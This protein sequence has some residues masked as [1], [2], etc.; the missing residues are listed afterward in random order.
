MNEKKYLPLACNTPGS[1]RT[2][3]FVT[4]FS[5]AESVRMSADTF[6]SGRTCLVMFLLVKSSR[7]LNLSGSGLKKKSESDRYSHTSRRALSMWARSIGL[8]SLIFPFNPW[9]SMS[10]V[11]TGKGSPYLSSE[12]SLSTRRHQTL[13]FVLRKLGRDLN[14][15]GSRRRRWLVDVSSA[16]G[17]PCGVTGN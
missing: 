16:C 14:D 6:W 5:M 12:E 7:G 10:E 13:Y 3:S 17:V 15:M 4:S 1:T 11:T 9:M 8:S 2:S